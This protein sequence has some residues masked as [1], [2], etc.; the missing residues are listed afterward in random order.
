MNITPKKFKPRGVL[1]RTQT[2]SDG[3]KGPPDFPPPINQR[4]CKALVT[5]NRV[6]V[7][8]ERQTD[9]NLTG[10]RTTGAS[11]SLAKSIATLPGKKT[12]PLPICQHQLATKVLYHVLEQRREVTAQSLLS[13]KVH[14]VVEPGMNL[15]HTNGGTIIDM[16]LD[17]PNSD[18]VQISTPGHGKKE[19]PKIPVVRRQTWGRP[20]LSCARIPVQYGRPTGSPCKRLPVAQRH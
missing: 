11:L 14:P 12:S 16:P 18:K 9:S 6:N 4:T 1:K 17:P 10:W 15:I 2:V 13:S 3:S 5:N 7:V 20:S 8:L 19:R